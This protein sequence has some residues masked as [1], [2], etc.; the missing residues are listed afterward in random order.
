MMFQIE[1][2][3]DNSFKA[4]GL[5]LR[6]HRVRAGYSLRDLGF[7]TNISHTLIANIEQGKVA[8]N[9][10]T[11][12]DLFASLKVP[13]YDTTD[14]EDEFKES[15]DRTFD[16]LFKYDYTRATLEMNK[17]LENEE[18][19]RHSCLITDYALIK[20]FY[21]VLLGYE[22]KDQYITLEVLKKVVGNFSARQQQLFYLIEGIDYYNQGFY[23]EAEE[24]LKLA[25]KIGV[26]HLDYL[27]RV[28]LV[29]CYVKMYRFMDVISLGNQAIDFFEVHII[30]LRAME[31][32]LSIAY[33]YML[34]KKFKDSEELLDSVSQFS[35]N[36]NAIYLIEE[37]NM[38][39]AELYINTNRI[40]KAQEML[41]KLK[42][43]SSTKYYLKIKLAIKEKQLDEA[44]EIYEQF[45][46]EKLFVK[47]RKQHIVINIMVSEA[48]ISNMTGEKFIAE[49]KELIQIGV[50]SSDL[51]IIDSSYTYLIKHYKKKR[52]YKKALEASEKARDYRRYG[53][54]KL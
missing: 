45:K 37:S 11:L 9:S 31:V 20:F 6:V 33:S 49:I 19:Y 18:I 1:L 38:I 10:D 27:T 34:V 51:E 24:K 25:L 12:K 53:F 16:F 26:S 39:L 29:K 23:S 2:N 28:F 44:R 3:T 17:L 47:S 8:G 22:A 36:F 14:I 48:G 50:R 43:T 46:A 40:S 5:F 35:N 4:L 32:R 13:Y 42:D 54:L 30:Y 7:I 15:Y 21:L 52:M 41:G